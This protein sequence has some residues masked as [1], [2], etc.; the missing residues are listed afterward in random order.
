MSQNVEQK[1]WDR[2]YKILPILRRVPFLRMVAVCNNLAFGKVSE[3][4]DIDLF[5]IAKKGRLFTVRTIITVLLHLFGVR[6]HGDKVAGRFC[7]SF[8]TDDSFLDLS[9]IAIKDDIY[10][11]YW[12]KTMIPVLDDGIYRK[13][14]AD[15]GWISRYVDESESFPHSRL[16]GSFER[17]FFK[18]V[19]NGYWGDFNEW[20][21]RWWQLRRALH[22]TKSASAT[23]SLIVNEHIL[24]FHNIDRRAEYRDAWI[25]KYGILEKVTCEKFLQL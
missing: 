25:K 7:L 8:F 24:K 20:I 14:I 18:F 5:I 10:L 3:K 9:K 13:F 19:L 16:L 12:I 22:K 1:L 21:L 23:A 11:A 15:N 4:S 6:R 2:V 17:G